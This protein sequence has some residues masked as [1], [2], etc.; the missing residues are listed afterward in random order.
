MIDM[1]AI[2]CT[3]IGD[4]KM[5]QILINHLRSDDFFDVERHPEASCR[6]QEVKAVPGAT[7][8]LPEVEIG[9][10][11]NL[12]GKSHPL[13]FAATTGLN[14]EARFAAQASFAFD[15]TLW[16]S[17]YGSGKFFKRVGRYLVNDLIEMQV[18]LLV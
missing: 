7:P 6:I 14:V 10:E 17:I 1:N 4:S 11:L 16:D 8:G 13:V 9:G 5:R 15:R 2:L 18:R 12:R 3:D